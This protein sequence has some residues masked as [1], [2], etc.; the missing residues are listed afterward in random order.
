MVSL[1][2]REMECRRRRDELQLNRLIAKAERTMRAL[3]FF[4]MEL[5]KFTRK[6]RFWERLVLTE[7]TAQ[8]AATT[9]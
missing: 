8:M 7:R 5:E 3:V 1:W 9:K 4:K 6:R 2:C